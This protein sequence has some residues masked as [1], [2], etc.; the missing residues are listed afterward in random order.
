MAV[1]INEAK[2]ERNEFGLWLGWTLATALGMLLGHLP[3]VPLVEV[4]DLGIARIVAPLL[5]GLLVGL[6]QWL[7][8]RGFLTRSSDWILAGGAGWA[9]A[10]AI[11]LFVVQNLTGSFLIGLVA[12][13]L[14][15]V[16]VG[17]LQWPVLRREIPNI[18]AWI[19][20]NVLG[21]TLGFFVSQIVVGQLFGPDS[22]NQAL[23]TA[24][25]SGVSGFIAGAL[26]G[27]AL[28]WIV[29]QPELEL[30]DILAQD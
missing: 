10:Y 7:V 21:W 26:T 25:S 18:W 11:G 3:L 9:A 29:R 1:D 22:Y 24:I 4:I 15:G 30:E 16:I 5:G 13:L 19:S 23:V 17:L 20:A 2:V 28:V 12:Y 6:S 27:L 8:L 14:F